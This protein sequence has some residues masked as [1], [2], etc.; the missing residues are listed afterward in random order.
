MN[1]I[2]ILRNNSLRWLTKGTLR[3]YKVGGFW[4]VEPSLSSS[5]VPY[6]STKMALNYLGNLL[7]LASILLA[8]Q[9]FGQTDFDW[10]S[11]SLQ[12]LFWRTYLISFVL[13]ISASDN[14]T[15]VDCYSP[16][17]QCCRL[18]VSPKAPLRE[19]PQFS[20]PGSDELLQPKRWII[21][22]GPHQDSLSIEW[23][24]ELPWTRSV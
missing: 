24:S 10:G 1:W 22:T 19:P 11:V 6:S 17:T 2:E 21:L 4:G 3:T 13:Q 9:V 16:S 5:P 14:L 18:N 12:T 15:W 23:N 20:F 7:A 8:A